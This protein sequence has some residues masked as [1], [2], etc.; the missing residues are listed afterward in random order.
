MQKLLL[1]LVASLF[2]GKSYGQR[3]PTQHAK[4]DSFSVYFDL[5][6]PVLNQKAK[7]KID[8]LIYLDKLIPGSNIMIVGYADYLGSEGHNQ[9]LSEQ[10]AKAV[11]DYLLSYN[12]SKE[13]ITICI[14]KGAIE[15]NIRP[16]N[17]IGYPTDRKVDI[18][19]VKKEKKETSQKGKSTKP[20]ATVKNT[21]PLKPCILSNVEKGA[22][23]RLNHLYFLPQRHLFTKSSVTELT[24]VYEALRDNPTIKIKIEGHVCCIVNYDDA[25]DVDT[26]DEHLSLNRAKAVYDFLIEKG[27]DSSRLKYEG[28]G[29]SKPV[30]AN[31][32]TEDDANMN[33]RVEIRILEK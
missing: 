31:E 32:E 19:I 6:V 3:Q 12:F 1:I 17:I 4:Q 8:S 21:V 11:Q 28:F 23:F 26:H 13:H 16:K 10:R 22:T 29:K 9:H 5:D 33:R 14:G 24:K 25:L 18:V 7:N 20:T 15:R 27:I 2:I 30:I